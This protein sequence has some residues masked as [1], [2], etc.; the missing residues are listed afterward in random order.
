VGKLRTQGYKEALEE[1]GIAYRENLVV[2]L[3]DEFNDEGQEE[4]LMTE[5]ELFLRNNPGVDGIFAVN[6][7]Y[8]LT[9]MKAARKLDRDIPDQLKVIGFTDGDLSKFATPS[10]TTVSQ[11]GIQLG[12]KAA[13]ILIKRLEENNFDPPY[14]TVVVT[15]RLVER[16]STSSH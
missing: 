4:R 13:E 3:R 16:E 14:Q 11:H 10:L 5:I 6:E 8:A 2:K 1:S 15:T 12:E 7:K 9:A